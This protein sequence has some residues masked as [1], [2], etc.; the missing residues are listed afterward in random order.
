[1]TS[2][3]KLDR[4]A[5]SAA[6]DMLKRSS[7][8]LLPTH[9]NVDADS[10]SSV[11]ALKMALEQMNIRAEVL[12]TDGE[13]PHSLEFLPGVDNVLL[14][15]HDELPQYDVVLMADHSDRTRGGAF[16]RD[17]PSRVNGDIPIIN[18]DHHVTNDQ[19]GVVNIIQ[20]GAASTTEILAD[21][22]AVWG[23]VLTRDIAQCLLAGIYGDTL[24]LRTESTTARTMRTSADLVDN[25]GNPVPI[26]NALF[27]LKSREA[28]LLWRAALRGVSW[29]GDL[30]WTELTQKMFDETRAQRSEAEGMVNFLVGTEGSRAAAL[31]YATPTGWRVSMRSMTED[32]DVAKIAAHFGGGGHPRAAGLQIEGDEQAKQDFLENVAA[33][34]RLRPEQ[35]E[36]AYVSDVVID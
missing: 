5:A 13:V 26:V 23:T 17:D 28:V 19:F 1:M 31:L 22:L 8:V 14:Y 7:C 4:D 27:R 11:L 29:T 34:I 32:V 9:Q 15:G 6:L 35:P 20:P 2:P 21:V 12:V 24:G 25:G 36:P 33:M 30:I 16:Y 18:I 3:W 10:L